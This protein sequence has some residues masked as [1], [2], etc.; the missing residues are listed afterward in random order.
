LSAFE[1][2]AV[3]SVTNGPRTLT[4]SGQGFANVSPCANLAL[5]GA[6]PPSSNL[7]IGQPPCVGG[8]FQNFTWQYSRDGDGCASGSFSATVFAVDTQGSNASATQTVTLD[9]M[10]E[11]CATRCCTLDQKCADPFNGVCCG[12]DAGPLCGH[13]GDTLGGPRC[14]GPEDT[15][16]PDACCSSAGQ[17]RS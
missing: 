16:T 10:P 7:K 3:D 15:C 6:P 11:N 14:C 8:S 1:P 5:E 13:S 4:I 12:L 9:S 17:E 2:E